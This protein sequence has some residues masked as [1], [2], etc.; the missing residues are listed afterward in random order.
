MGGD[1]SDDSDGDM[2]VMMVARVMGP[3][4]FHCFLPPIVS[5]KRLKS[6]VKLPSSLPGIVAPVGGR[7]NIVSNSLHIQQ[8]SSTSGGRG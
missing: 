5:C 6:T 4:F 3:F 1:G 2:V 7:L 8:I